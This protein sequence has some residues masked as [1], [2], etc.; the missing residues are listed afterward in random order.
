MKRAREKGYEFEIMGVSGYSTFPFSLNGDLF[1]IC[2]T[3][4]KGNFITENIS[5]PV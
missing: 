2:S 5:I 1:N 3:L 4:I